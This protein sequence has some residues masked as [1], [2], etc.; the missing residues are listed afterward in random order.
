MS[1]SRLIA[2][3]LLS[4][5]ACAHGLCAELREPVHPRRNVEQFPAVTA[6]YIRFIV[7]RTNRGEPGIDELEIYGPEDPSRNLALAA[8]GARASSSGALPG[9]QIHELQG[10]NDVLYGNGHCWI[11]DRTE[12]AWVQ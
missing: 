9:Y 7:Q 11:A 1:G 3:A 4:L 8:N 6:K 10:L 5:L 12:G 2:F